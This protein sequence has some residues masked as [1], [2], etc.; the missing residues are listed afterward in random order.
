MLSFGSTA[1][2]TVV[3]GKVVEAATGTPIPFA[4]VIFVGTQQGTITDFDGN[5]EVSTASEVDSVEV[6]YVGFIRKAKPVLSGKTQIINFQMDEDLVTLGEVVVLSGENPAFEIL[7]RVN[8]NKE[9]NDKRSLDA[10][11][12]ESYT[13]IEVD[14]DNVSKTLTNRKFVAKIQNVM[15]SIEVI[16]GED[17][18]PVL[19]VFLS[20]AISTY[21]YRKE[22]TLTHEQVHKTKVSGVGITDGTTSSQIIGSTFQQYNFYRNWMT[23]ISKEFVSPIADGGRLYYEYDLSDS[24]YVGGEYC[25]KID[26]S[27]KRPQ[28]LA[29]V[30][31]MWI[32]KEDYALKRID[33]TVPK[34]ANLNFIQKLKIQQDLVRTNEGPWL[35]EK[36][37]VVVDVIQMTKLTAGFIA[38]FY[39]STKDYV[40]NQ[41]LEKSHYMNPI[42]MDEDIT[43][44]NEEYWA[45]AR[46]DSLTST[47]VNVFKMIDTL[48]Q[49]PLVKYGMGAGKFL[50]NGYH[51]MGMIDIG[52]YSTFYGSNDIEGTRIG[53][54]ARSTIAFS[55]KWVLGGYAGYGFGD[56]RWK[57][58]ASLERIL[59]REPWST[60]KL[61]HQKEVEQVWLLN[62]NLDPNGLFF[63]LSRFGT[64]TQPFR[65]TKT[66]LSYNQQWGTGFNTRI[67]FKHQ[68]N[69]PLFDF[70]Y[71]TNEPTTGLASA[72]S[73]NEASIYARYAKDELFVIDDNQRQSLGTRYWPAFNFK[74]T[75]GFKGDLGGDFNYHKFQFGLDRRQKMAFLGIGKMSL[76]AGYILGKIPYT[77]LYN[78]IGNETPVYVD[79]SYNLMDYF[80]FSMDKWV[81]FRYRHSFEG[82][83]LNGI[84]LLK[85]LKLREIA[86][87]DILY[88]RM[89]NEKA[90]MTINP[91]NELGEEIPL[92]SRLDTRP[93]IELGYGVENI[94]RLLTVQ[95]FHRITYRDYPGVNKFGLKFLIEINL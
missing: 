43:E 46:H 38:K 66:R 29:F 61:E 94:A 33:A 39:I 6:R 30:G 77:L 2:S 88:G 42:S 91:L 53:M 34:S 54:G 32:T 4:N 24:L 23:I 21:Y 68:E 13:K 5:Y 10:Y 8:A 25:Y 16:A 64:L 3:S 67:D 79:F 69:N 19:P 73:I 89:S 14:V 50:F 57:Y 31:T 63:S 72:Y 45:E 52:P 26:Y 51:R 81:E 7:R 87:V 93:Y 15:D 17:G 83:F 41:P 22:P 49:I 28:D 76:S 90:N 58:K 55:N 9:R 85:K 95:A 78:P 62:Q 75:A 80:E 47:E 65:M 20:E 37:R 1:Q 35:P 48:K 44:S 86:S 92:F 71:R 70:Q 18:R 12:Y 56:G 11:Q 59:S 36:T 82:L 74:Y 84:P 27:P 60:L 40:I